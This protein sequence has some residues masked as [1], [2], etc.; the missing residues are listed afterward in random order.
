M[1]QGEVG[2]KTGRG[3]LEWPDGKA[4]KVKARSDGFIMEFLRQERPANFHSN[5]LL[6]VIAFIIVMAS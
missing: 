6:L 1:A 2:A 3:F 4:D 5:G